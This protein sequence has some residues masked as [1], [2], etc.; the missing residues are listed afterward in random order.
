[1]VVEHVGAAD[2][3]HTC[4]AAAAPGR[5]HAA[6]RGGRRGG[7]HGRHAARRAHRAAAAAG[8]AGGACPA[9]GWLTTR[10]PRSCPENCKVAPRACPQGRQLALAPAPA[11]RRGKAMRRSQATP[12]TTFSPPDAAE[13]RTGP[14]RPLFAAP[15]GKS[16]GGGVVTESMRD[17]PAP[18]RRPQAPQATREDKDAPPGAASASTAPTE[19][20]PSALA[21]VPTAETPPFV[22]VSRAFRPD[23][24]NAHRNFAE[25]D[26]RAS[27]ARLEGPVLL[28]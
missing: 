25:P 19:S 15:A 10:P 22:P 5:L 27:N 8:H 4:H 12:R 7:R 11:A 1:M 6:A 24:V 3:C 26:D 21:S 28:S 13:G 20:P 2:P 23:G 18:A 16:G 9:Y 14:C 17:P